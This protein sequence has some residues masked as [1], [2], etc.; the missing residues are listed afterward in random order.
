MKIAVLRWGREILVDAIAQAL[1]T[2]SYEV[3]TIQIDPETSF[4]EFKKKLE[5]FNPDFSLTHN[6]YIF[7]LWKNANELE[8][9]FKKSGRAI[10]SWFWEPP[11]ATGS[12]QMAY[13]WLGGPFP[14]SILF[15]VADSGYIPFFQE[16]GMSAIH[17]QLGVDSNYTKLQFSEQQLSAHHY[18]IFFAGLPGGNFEAT[19]ENEE[20][21][22]THYLQ[23][24]ALEFDRLLRSLPSHILPAEQ[25][26]SVSESL[27]PLM[28]QFFSKLYAGRAEYEPARQK[29]FQSF[30]PIVSRNLLRCL[31]AFSG[32]IDFCYSWYQM[33]IY[34]TRLQRHGL[35]VF[36]GEKWKS[37]L[38][39]YSHETP[40][41]SEDAMLASMAASSICF[42]FTKHGFNSVAHERLFKILAVGGFP[43]SDYRADVE[44]L[45]EKDEIVLYRTWD[46]LEDLVKFYLSHE[47]ARIKIAR[48]GKARIIKDHT[49]EVR[50]QQ[51]V[52]HVRN[53]RGQTY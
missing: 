45:F 41:L 9:F 11:M 12:F 24:M 37:L 29:L 14:T 36:G 8:E 28:D 49:L 44:L 34:L 21:L 32:R 23:T 25:V 53:F 39:G 17:F 47:D 13:R 40:H 1:Q 33:N 10:A 52:Q 7:D 20:M 38:P 48:K 2:N 50:A 27:F 46:E 22:R 30:E 5:E 31:V 51:L 42:N 15:L 35:R 26:S 6:L 19:C 16:R 3:L 43:L 18:P 4:E